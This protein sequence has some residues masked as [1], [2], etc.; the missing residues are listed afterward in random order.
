MFQLRQAI[1][2]TIPFYVFG[3]L[4]F[5]SLYSIYRAMQEKSGILHLESTLIQKLQIGNPNMGNLESEL[6]ESGVIYFGLR[7]TDY[8]C[9]A[10]LNS[11]QI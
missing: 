11:N 9:A 3:C 4:G 5:Q 10:N 8:R 1:H 6:S 7:N 2:D